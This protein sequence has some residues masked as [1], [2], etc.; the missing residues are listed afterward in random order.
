MKR[1]TAFRGGAWVT[2][3]ALGSVAQAA[4]TID[5]NGAAAPDQ[6][7]FN[8]SFT[9][10]QLDWAPGNSIAQG[11]LPAVDDGVGSEFNRYFQ[12]RLS[13]Y[14]DNNGNSPLTSLN[15]G[16]P[17]VG[18]TPIE[19]TMVAG[20]RERV[21]QTTGGKSEFELVKDNGA[22]N[23]LEIYYDDTPDADELSGTGYSNGRLILAAAIDAVD[24]S[25]LEII[26]SSS[27]PLDQ[28]G[29]NDYP[30]TQTILAQASSTPITARVLEADTGFF[31]GDVLDSNL[32]VDLLLQN[33][34]Q[35]LPFLTVNPSAAFTITSAGVGVGSLVGD[36]AD[37]SVGVG[38]V[39]AI[40]G[41]NGPD[42]MF[43]VDFNSRFSVI[44][45]PMTAGL[46]LMSLGALALGMR[47]RRL[48]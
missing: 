4:V 39:G 10:S 44:P 7:I 3:L 32:I 2:A 29:N 24:H 9:V 25:D 33:V 15:L 17:P 43:Q 6:G 46:G 26:P 21:T 20:F 47:R 1:S 8:Q 40:N 13:S 18:V 5:P 38:S 45:E 31:G 23:F 36:R 16:A 28:F 19:W 48:A 27:E 14:V 35:N 12:T 22:V 41:V 37:S 42:V 11:V 34:S 30:N